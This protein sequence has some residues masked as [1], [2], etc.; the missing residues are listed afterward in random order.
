MKAILVVDDDCTLRSGIKG[1][2]ACLF[3]AIEVFEAENGRDGLNIAQIE[4]P[5]MIL[6]D[7]NMPVMNG[8]EMAQ[9][10]KKHPVTRQTPLIGISGSNPHDPI[11]YGLWQ[12]CDVWLPKPFTSADLMRLIGS[13]VAA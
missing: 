1:L 7:G 8:Y 13:C 6:L 10:L 3:P 12:L 9:I 2:V 11:T 5:D 4:L